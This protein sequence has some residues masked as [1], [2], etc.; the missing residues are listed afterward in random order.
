[1]TFL[2]IDVTYLVVQFHVFKV[3]ITRVSNLKFDVLHFR[4]QEERGQLLINSIFNNNCQVSRA[5]IG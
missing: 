2:E 4:N 1:M 5:L 3:R